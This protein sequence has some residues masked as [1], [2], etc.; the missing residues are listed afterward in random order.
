MTDWVLGRWTR[1]GQ[2]R[3]YA[4][5]PGGTQLGYLDLKTKL[6]HP[7]QPSDLPILEAAVAGYLDTLQPPP[8]KHA[9]P[10]RAPNRMPADS[11][12]VYIPRHETVDWH[13]LS[14]TAPGAA[15]REQAQPLKQAT[16][17]RTVVSRVLGVHTDERSWRIGADG[18][19]A[20]GAQ[21]A[22][23]GPSWRTNHAVRVGNKGSDIDHVVIGPPGVFT[24]NTK[25][26][27]D[28][29]IWVANNTFLINGHHH[30]YVRNSRHEAGRASRLLEAVAGRLVAVHGIIAVVGAAG[31]FTVKEQPRDGA[32][33]VVGRRYLTDYLARL[34]VQ[35]SASDIDALY[36]LACR[37][38]TWQPLRQ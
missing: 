20:V 24:V 16:P 19:E 9:V 36:T 8:G 21:L 18:E 22:K 33:Y 31:G 26:H 3:L 11:S 14:D 7:E 12:A 4:K 34:P 25:H 35:L 32:V 10:E 30:P 13:D 1:Y 5:T 2:D 15:A 23:L 37:S 29:N 28:A 17:I 6:L 27:P 38:T